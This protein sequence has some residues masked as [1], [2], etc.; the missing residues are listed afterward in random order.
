MQSLIACD[1]FLF[2]NGFCFNCQIACV[3]AVVIKQKGALRLLD[4]ICDAQGR[5]RL[6]LL[7]LYFECIG[8]W[9]QQ[10]FYQRQEH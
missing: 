1:L 4:F 5:Q 8:Q 3:C 9:K 2:V 10:R 6:R 7:R